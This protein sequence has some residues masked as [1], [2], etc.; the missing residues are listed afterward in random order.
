MFYKFVVTTAAAALVALATVGP[1]SAGR[2]VIDR[3]VLIAS[4][5]YPGPYHYPHYRGYQPG[6]AFYHPSRRCAIVTGTRRWCDQW[7]RWHRV[8]FVERRCF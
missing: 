3:N 8:G 4:G 2:L 1:A 5:M 7:G 6:G